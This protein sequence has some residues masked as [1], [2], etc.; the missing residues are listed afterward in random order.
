[1]THA[2]PAWEEDEF[3]CLNL[4]ASNE[5]AD[6]HI[7]IQ[8]RPGY[9][10]RGHFSAGCSVLLKMGPEGTPPIENI[11][12]AD[13]FARYYMHLSTAKRELEAFA[14]WRLWKEYT[15][16]SDPQSI[17]LLRRWISIMGRGDVGDLWDETERFVSGAA[18]PGRPAAPAR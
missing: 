16:E 13:G 4:L 17:A 9:C 11:D 10:D 15:P 12:G 7:W 18:E 3:G 6:L 5:R 14:R 2:L 1:M 8:K